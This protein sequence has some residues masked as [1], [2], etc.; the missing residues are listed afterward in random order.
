MAR[1]PQTTTTKKLRKPWKA[2][3]IER[4][5]RAPDISRAAKAARI[6]R[7]TAYEE[8]KKDVEFAAAWDD[9]LEEAIERAEAELYRRAVLGIKKPVY[10]GKELVGHIQDYSDLLLI[11][12]LKAHKPKYRDTVRQEH[13]GPGGG[14]IQVQELEAIRQKRWKQAGP[15]LRTAL[16]ELQAEGEPET[17]PNGDESKDHA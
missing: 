5:R 2:A 4:L 1:P 17:P 16:A 13:S 10:Q 9:A 6:H 11:F 3:F 8:R 15:M 12:M 7:K 14:P